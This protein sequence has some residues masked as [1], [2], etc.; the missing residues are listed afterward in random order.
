[1]SRIF[2]S[3]TYEDLIEHR[4]AITD[5]LTRMKQEHSVMEFFGSRTD[6][7]VPA[8]K[9]EI[10][11]SFFLVGI[12]AWRYGWIPPGST[13][14]ITEQEFDYARTSD[15]KCLCYVVSEQ[16]PWPPSFIDTGEK[17]ISLNCFKDK[18]SMLVRSEFTTPDNLAK[19]V[20]A[21]LAR[22]MA[23]ERSRNSVGG[24]LQLNWDALSPELQAIFVDAYKR[25]K[26]G[27]RDGTVA[28]RHVIAA[29]LASPN[30][31][32]ILL[33]QMD[34]ALIDEML[35]NSEPP[36]KIDDA[37]A[38]VQVFRHEKSFSFCVLGSLDRLLPT[39]SAKDRVVALEL[40]ADLLKNGRGKSVE[41]FRRANIDEEAVNRLMRHAERISRD[42]NRIFTALVSFTDAEIAM[43]NYA[44][45]L[46]VEPGVEGSELREAVVKSAQVQAKIDV[47]VGELMRRKPD[48]LR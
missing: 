18:V 16:H 35:R 26:E 14:S 24:L 28:T 8:C 10:D 19:Q 34:R 9:K 48:L 46:A 43:I 40:A 33:N 12:Y 41:K 39:H 27:S 44:I 13:R 20:A 1:M 5:V 17:R 6:E 30:S 4:K 25:A 21:D 42:P 36:A 2:I 29:L 37:V 3:S 22:E 11:A 47:L 45:G 23:P 38:L 32:G 31:S 15:K 7:A